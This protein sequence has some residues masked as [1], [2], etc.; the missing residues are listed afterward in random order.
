MAP[1]RVYE[2]NRKADCVLSLKKANR[3]LSDLNK[4]KIN[5]VLQASI[6]FC[7][8]RFPTGICESCRSTLRRASKG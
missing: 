2:Q 1:A 5:S 3:E 7:D 4:E 6:N 8:R